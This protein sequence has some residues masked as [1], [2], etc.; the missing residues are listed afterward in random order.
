MDL[1]E[2]TLVA[3]EIAVV[4]EEAEGGGEVGAVEVDE[5]RTRTYV[6]SSEKMREFIGKCSPLR[7]RHPCQ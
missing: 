4:A 1:R 7:A 3:E 2:V 5:R 6:E